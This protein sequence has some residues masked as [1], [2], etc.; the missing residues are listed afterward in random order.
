MFSLKQEDEAWT[1]VGNS[2]NA[3]RGTV[4]AELEERRK[5]FPSAKA[6]GK[7]RSTEDLALWDISEKD[8]PDYFGGNHGLELARNLV[9]TERG[10]QSAL[11]QRMADLEYTVSYCL[12]ISLCMS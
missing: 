9:K 11:V 1:E 5:E 7:Q 12:V 6:K 2:Y 4:L 10:E 8:L 3:F